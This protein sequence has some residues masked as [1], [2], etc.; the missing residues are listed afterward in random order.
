MIRK[1]KFRHYRYIMTDEGEIEA[2]IVKLREHVPDDRTDTDIR[3]LIE[4]CG[5][6]NVSKPFRP[7]LMC[8][9]FNAK[10]FTGISFHQIMFEGC[11]S[12]KNRGVVGNWR[13]C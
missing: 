9:H 3:A 1:E 12:G 5:G 8:S 11:H 6:D 2:E 13:R 10:I 7:A 4:E